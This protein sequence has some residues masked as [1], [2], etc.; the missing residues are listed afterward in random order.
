MTDEQFDV[1]IVG[2]GLAG[3]GTASVLAR[4]G[5]DVLVLERET[6][7]RDRVRGE[8]LAPWGILEL[9]ALGLRG[10]ADSVPRANLITRHVGYDECTTPAEAEAAILD[11]AALIPGGGC[12]A[13]GHPQF[14]E[15]LLANAVQEGAIV[16][17]GVDS[18]HVAVGASPSVSYE[19]DGVARTVSC[20][21]VVG[22]TGANPALARGSASNWTAHRPRSSW[23][24]CSS[25]T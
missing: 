24:G 8:W 25:T 14:Q 20:R 13:I 17:R 5:I 21:L 6:A 7:F 15:A 11:I 1:V 3:S 23:P 19:I 18:V 4:A 2:G 10:V 16:R 12:L 22:A 9:E